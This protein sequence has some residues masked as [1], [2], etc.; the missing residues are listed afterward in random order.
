MTNPVEL[1]NE[2]IMECPK[3]KHLFE[4]TTTIRISTAWEWMNGLPEFPHGG[5]VGTCA[6][7]LAREL[8][9]SRIGMMGFDFYEKPNPEMSVH[10]ALGIEHL[11]YPGF[12]TIAWPAHMKAYFS[13]MA[14]VLQD[15]AAEVRYLGNS[16]LFTN[17]PLVESESVEDFLEGK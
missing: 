10:E 16:P 7:L 6:F 13:Y 8:D 12:G 5:N 4:H 14:G 15:T 9:Y 3:C 11:Y 17:C 1:S 2:V